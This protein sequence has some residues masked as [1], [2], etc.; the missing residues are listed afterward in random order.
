MKKVMVSVISSALCFG[1]IS[2]VLTSAAPATS[3]SEIDQVSGLEK[4]NF[5]FLEGNPG[6]LYLVYTYES[7]GVTYKVE[8]HSNEDYT[9]VNSVIYQENADGKFVEF[10]TQDTVVDNEKSIIQL[11]TDKG[12]VTTSESQSIS[13]VESSVSGIP[14]IRSDLEDKFTPMDSYNGTPV[15]P[16]VYNSWEQGSSSIARYTLT[17]VVAALSSIAVKYAPGAYKVPA[18]AVGAMAALFVSDNVQTVYYKQRYGQKNSAV[19]PS[20]IVAN[21]IDTLYYVEPGY[22][23]LKGRTSPIRSLPGYVE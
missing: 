11:T 2:P 5:V 14:A 21:Q 1:I 18:A 15:K 6:D 19:A 17:G 8:E 3:A 20:V 13:N 7:E 12:G 10:S 23:Y 4:E 16:W 9:E 22:K